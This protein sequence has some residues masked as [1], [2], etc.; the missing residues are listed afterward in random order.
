MEII[1]IV[2]L[3]II[4]VYAPASNPVVKFL[5]VAWGTEKA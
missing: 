3:I 5:L 4:G 1:F 2:L